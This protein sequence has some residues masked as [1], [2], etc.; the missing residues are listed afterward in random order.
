MKHRKDIRLKNYDY[1]TNGYY[2]VTIC[3]A[4]RRL[5]LEQY[6]TEVEILLKDMPKRFSGITIDFYSIASNHLH[7]I[8]VLNNAKA[9]LGDIVRT[10]KALV[11]KSAGCK[12][13]WEWNYY[14]HIIRDEKALYNIR[15]YIQ[16]N[17]L[18][19]KIDWNNIYGGINATAT[20]HCSGAI[21]RTNQGDAVPCPPVAVRFIALPRDDNAKGVALIIV[22]F[23]M[24]LFAVLGWTLANLQ[25]GDFEANLRNLDSEQA[26]SLAEAGAEWGLR[27]LTT[28]PNFFTATNPGH[29]DDDCI[30]STDW[31]T[32]TFSPGQ[33]RVCCRNP[34]PSEIGAN[35][36]IE[37]EGYTPTANPRARRQV[38]LMVQFGLDRAVQTQPDDPA[39]SSQGLFNWWPA[40]GSINIRGRISAGH[41]NGD[42]DATLDEVPGDFNTPPP[43]PRQPPGTGARDRTPSFPSIDMAEFEALANAS[44][45]APRTAKI[46]GISFVGG[47]TELTLDPDPNPSIFSFPYPQWN[48]DALR[49]LS[50]GTFQAG[51]WAEISTVGGDNQVTLEGRISWGLGERI[52]LI[53]RIAG[54]IPLPGNEFQITLSSNY[55]TSPFTNWNNQG[56][57]NLSKGGSWNYTDWG[58]IKPGSVS[59]NQVT[60]IMDSAGIPFTWVAG[61]LLGVVRRFTASPA[62][63]LWYIQGD[64]LLDLRADNITFTNK[65]FISEGDITIKG[66]NQIR[67]RFAGGTTPYPNLAS[68]NGNIISLD[69]VINRN[70]RRFEGLIYSQFGLVN[71]NYLT[72]TLVYGHRITLD[73]D[74][75]IDYEQESI[76]PNGFGLAS[77]RWQEQ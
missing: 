76:S 62:G 17:P 14:E 41:Y 47:N 24:M 73:G 49:N 19:E 12:P 71:L 52:C 74:I 18:K 42:G 44:W 69:T 45:S 63:N 40:S 29:Q 27:Q 35:K 67:M 51:N 31:R 75:D 61:E 59:A 72:G 48:N 16:E 32:H 5:W 25:S 68:K 10:F 28:T 15:K 57:R 64:T 9:R 33:Y 65:S 21:Y 58:V 46:S 50:R 7:I 30:D 38:R 26:L 66:T 53:P 4:M 37:T 22:I 20:T 77:L 56:L 55:F 60:V 13:F 2:F 3:T 36:V 39:D 43:P 34:T 8:F 11:T 6:K 23:A 54:I 1:K 70:R